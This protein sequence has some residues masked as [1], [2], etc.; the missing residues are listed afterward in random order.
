[1][2]LKFLE[3]WVKRETLNIQIPGQRGGNIPNKENKAVK[4]RKKIKGTNITTNI[5]QT[6]D[7]FSF[8]VTSLKSQ[9]H[10]I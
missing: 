8:S 6:S 5:K 4:S 3:V 7:A 10:K 9:E 2:D 1:M